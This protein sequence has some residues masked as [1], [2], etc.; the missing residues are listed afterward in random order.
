MS[1]RSIH[2]VTAASLALAVSLG[3]C[4]TV[5]N[6]AWTAPG[7]Y[8]EQPRLVEAAGPQFLGGPFS[9]D[10]CEVERLKTQIPTRL[11]CINEK[12]PPGSFGPYYLATPAPPA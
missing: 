4:D 9:Y 8:L 12:I 6:P 7:W 11:L 1:E 5:P 3:A 2:R 10:Q